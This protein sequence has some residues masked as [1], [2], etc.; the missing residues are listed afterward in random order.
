MNEY[1]AK[2]KYFDWICLSG[3]DYWNSNPHSRYHISKEFSKNSRILWVNS[4]GHRFPSLKNRKG[5]LLIGR[6]IKSYFIFF[7]RP[8]SNFYVLSPLTIPV[9]KGKLINKINAEFLWIQIVIAAKLIGIKKEYYFV[10]SP[11]FGMIYSKL[12]NAFVIYYYSDLYTAF[13]ELKHKKEIEEN[14]LRLIAISKLVYGASKKI[15]ENLLYKDVHIKYLPHA[16]NKNHFEKFNGT[17]PGDIKN[18]PHPIIGYYGTIT[19]SNDWEII[20]YCSKERP[21]YQFVFIGK[22]FI[23]IPELEKRSNIHFVNKVPYELIPLYG[24]QFDVAIMFWVM[25]KWIQNSSPLK[26]LEYFALKKPVVSVDI[27]EVRERFGDLVYIA[28]D[29]KEFLSGIDKALSDENKSII[30]KYNVI[31]SEYSWE[32]VVNTIYDDIGEIKNVQ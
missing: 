11:S 24:K 25:R 26:L 22:K 31:L 14:D 27:P 5:W 28:K 29:K 13:R 6:K 8:E 1:N 10:S 20:D 23:S 2:N 16:V 12:K 18:I 21:S 9:F 4:I 15:C 7:R 17:I 30:E 3:D 32:K 19:D